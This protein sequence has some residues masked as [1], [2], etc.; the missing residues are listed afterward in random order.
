MSAIGI[1]YAELKALRP[2]EDR[3]RA[4]ARRFGGA[5]KWG[6]RKITA[7]EAVAAGVTLDDLVW[8]TSALARRDAELERR[9][10]LWM[11]D[12]AARVLCIYESKAPHDTRPRDAIVAARRFARGEIGV[13]ARAA[14]RAAAWV[15]ARAAAG[16]AAGAAAAAGDAARDAAAAGDAARDAAGVAARAAAGDAAG[17][18]EEQ[19][20]LQRLVA[21]LSDD[22]PDDWPL[23]PPAADSGIAS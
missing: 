6:S 11:A 4:S 23:D 20:Q 15:A 9:L 3:L 10:R 19:W 16:A 1:T 17:D 8:V 12:C 7:A 22:E 21:W 5:R 13:A 2:C 14:A 18:A